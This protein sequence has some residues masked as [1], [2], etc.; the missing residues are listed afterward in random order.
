MKIF[1]NNSTLNFT[2]GVPI[3]NYDE[4][5]NTLTGIYNSGFYSCINITRI[6]LYK[7]LSQGIIPRSISFKDTL[8]NYKEL[9]A[10][11]LYPLLY[12]TNLEA[13]KDIKTGFDFEYF[14]PTLINYKDFNFNFFSSIENTFFSPSNNVL[15]TIDSLYAKYN[16]IPSKTL[17]VL[18]R[19]NDKWREATLIDPS[20]WIDQ[21]ESQLD[22]DYK[23]L[24]QTDEQSTRDIF[25]NHFKDRAF[26]FDEMIFNNTYAKPICN[27]ENW[28]V[29]FESIMR[30]VSQC[31]KVI[32]HSG[33][34]GFIPTLY[35]NNTTNV[36]QL[37]RS[38]TFVL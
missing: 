1:L 30:I 29:Y 3:A 18:H 11:D 36:I 27:F 24:I 13:I 5:T 4:E 34:C 21:I 9:P 32:T 35:R 2:H 28:A 37:N 22:G 17:A 16:I 12:T 20:R 25:L 38:G 6:A 19:G 7:L 33:N 26:F 10:D 8:L 31:K 23:I 14:C 15:N